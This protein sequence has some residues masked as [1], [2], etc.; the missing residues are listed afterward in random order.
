M[1]IENNE[2]V[3]AT[4]WDK[5][6]ITYAENFI[7]NLPD[8]F[9]KPDDFRKLFCIIPSIVNVKYTIVFGPDGSKKGWELAKMG[10]ILRDKFVKFLESYTYEDG[11]NPW[12]WV[13]IGYGEFG[14]K[15]LKGN[16]ENKYDDREYYEYCE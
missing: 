5:K 12:D 3:I 6:L 1:G 13:E 9:K 8:D 14:Q 2:V 7:S 11:S 10:T 15:I 4:T 16:C